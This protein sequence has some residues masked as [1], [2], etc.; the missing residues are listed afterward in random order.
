ML[1]ELLES[2]FV[3]IQTTFRLL[4]KIC[5][6]AFAFA[7]LSISCRN[8]DSHQKENRETIPATE[9]VETTIPGVEK[10]AFS[11]T[12]QL[13]AGDNMRFDKELFR[14]RAGKKIRLI[15]FNTSP[16]SSGSM[17][18]NVVILVK[19]T[20][21]ADFADAVHNAKDEQYTPASVAPL[22]IAHTRMVPGGGSDAVEFVVVKPGVYDYICSFPGHWGTMQGKIVVE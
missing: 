9:N 7:L 15:L 3:L 10:L 2:F 1:G 18:H 22:I 20:D 19:G 11:D 17:T 8:T 4:G 12:I 5:A 14:V 21:I 6:Y 16:K 13:K